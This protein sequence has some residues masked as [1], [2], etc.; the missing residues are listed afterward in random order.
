LHE[1]RGPN[2]W[3]FASDEAREWATDVLSAA[4]RF[5]DVAEADPDAL[6]LRGR[7]AVWAIRHGD[8]R[9]V[10]RPYRRGGLLAAPLLGDKH[11]RWG[12]PRPLAEA[13][14]SAEV[15]SRGVPT[16]RVLA[17]AIYPAGAFYRADLVTE[18]VPD[19][20]D[21]A[22]ALFGGEPDSVRRDALTSSGR[23]V[24][25]MARAGV[26]HPDLNARNILLVGAARSGA[27]LLDLDRC[28][29][30]PAGSPTSP[31]KM[32][33]RLERSLA[34]IAGVH[35]VSVEPSDLSLL[36]AAALEAR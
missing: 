15:L 22:S 36:R 27:T 21:L 32:L 20:R 33:A 18:Y 14:A 13:F 7:G 23:L 8:L 28:R 6:V 25:E 12:T 16:P 3:G 10:V 4:R 11:L 26:E 24:G 1:L 30:R 31:A 34:K 35:G 17:G 5:R 19:S 2:G 9:W 29:L